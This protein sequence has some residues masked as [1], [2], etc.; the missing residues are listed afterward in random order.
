MAQTKLART[1]LS[2]LLILGLTDASQVWAQSG[3]SSAL[4]GTLVDRSGAAI[5][6]AQ[7]K[8]SEV[9]TGAVRVVESDGEG[10][11]LFSQV[12]P[13]TYRIEARVAGFGPG[14]SQPT[15]VSVG[16][17][18]TVNFTLALAATSESVEVIVQSGLMSLENANTSAT[19][20]AKTIKSLP[21]PGQDLTYVAQFAEGA[22]MNT[23]GSSN[24]AKAAGG[25]GNVEFNGLPAT[26]N[27]YVLDG[28]DANDPFLG[29][30]IGLST[31]LVIGLDALQE[32]TVN[33]NSYAVDQGRYGASQV[34]YFTKSGTNQF[35]GDVYE[36]W[37]GS[38]FNGTDYFLH[39]NDTPGNV[40]KKPRSTVNEFGVSVGGPIRKNQ[41]FFF[42]HYEGIR[43]AL[44]LVARTTVPS[45][46]YQQYVLQQLPLGGVDPIDGASLPAQ[47]QEAAFYR[48][49]FALYSNTAGTPT[50]VLSCPLDANGA[51]LSGK[52]TSA[53]PF[54]GS[55]CANK[56]THSLNNSDSENLIVLKV[57]H[58]IDAN[59]SA[60]YRFQQD[61]G[62]QA[63][64][65]DPINAIFNSYSPQPQRTLV[66]GYTHV[67]TPN[68]VNQFNPGASWY[69]SLFQPNNYAK[70]LTAF[71]I[72]LDGG[73][74]NAPFTT[75]GGNDQTNTQGR[76]VTQWQLNDNLI[77]TRGRHTLK[78]GKTPAGWT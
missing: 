49:M 67:F 45:V 66:V 52:Q 76:K 23:A 16:Q 24:D 40:A 46:A 44:P 30:N 21:N 19:L 65:T 63:A 75:I 38:L 26:S 18:A 72:V 73:S 41:L 36:I 51:L 77:W 58:T 2:L 27:G 64:Y 57:D 60:W 4:S 37:N 3:T 5:A 13:G 59:N 42:A 34:N 11:F 25:Y 48:S 7:V 31:N 54:N 70:V 62:L 74:S 28:F 69:S 35:H 8:A 68:L 33:T 10:R 6:G 50:P 71:P 47:P 43:I 53:N 32:A 55:G 22:L 12:N 39:A 15:S 78:F 9:N 29:L 61:T 1:V 14:V 56:R 17:T 20:E